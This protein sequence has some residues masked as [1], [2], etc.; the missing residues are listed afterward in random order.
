MSSK[1]INLLVN[2]D[3]RRRER[4]L[5]PTHSLLWALVVAR[6]VLFLGFSKGRVERGQDELPLQVRSSSRLSEKGHDQ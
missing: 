3:L 1:S 6:T 2:I 5:M 4:L